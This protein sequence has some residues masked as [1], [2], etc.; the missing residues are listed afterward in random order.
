M[1]TTNILLPHH[2][3]TVVRNTADGLDNSALQ[4]DESYLMDNGLHYNYI[5]IANLSSSTL[6]IDGS[7]IADNI[8]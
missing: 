8:K 2:F 5:L 1:T 6:T 7:L 4:S 3:R